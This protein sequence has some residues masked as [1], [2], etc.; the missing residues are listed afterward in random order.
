MHVLT[1]LFECSFVSLLRFSFD[2][3]V[4]LAS[5]L[6]SH[7]NIQTSLFFVGCFFNVILNCIL[8]IL[9]IIRLSVLSKFYENVEVL[10]LE[11]V[12]LFISSSD[13]PSVAYEKQDN[14]P[15]GGHLC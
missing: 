2:S 12:E 11:A 1:F 9:T 6:L 15:K 14:R 5:N 3:N 7:L 8:D 10:F 4:S 13:Q